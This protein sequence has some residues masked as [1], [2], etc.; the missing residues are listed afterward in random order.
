MACLDTEAKK[1]VV[2]KDQSIELCNITSLRLRPVIKP[3]NFKFGKGSLSSSVTIP[4]R[5]PTPDGEFINLKVDVVNANITLLLGL[6]IMSQESQEGIS[7]EI[8]RDVIRH[9]HDAWSRPLVRFDGH[10]HLTWDLSEI[11]LHALSY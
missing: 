3:K 11:K 10:L 6:D 5:I 9:P 7:I 8:N 1:S 2:G 4:V